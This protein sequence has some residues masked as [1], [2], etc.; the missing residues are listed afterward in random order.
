MNTGGEI[1]RVLGVF[2]KN[3]LT[4]VTHQ[5]VEWVDGDGEFYLLEDVTPVWVEYMPPS[6][7]L[8]SVAEADID[9][10][11][12][13]ER[14]A[15]VLAYAAAGHLLRSDGRYDAG[16]EFLSLA[17]GEANRLAAKIRPRPWERRVIAR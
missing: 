2:D 17:E 1:D 6:P 9:S 3:P 13:P 10:E 16:S 14:F 4:D 5:P 11:E 7:S 15:L 8:L 12:L